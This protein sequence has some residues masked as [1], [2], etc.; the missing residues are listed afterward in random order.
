MA[1]VATLAGP[2]RSAD[3]IIQTLG[4]ALRIA[5]DGIQA[6]DVQLVV[7]M[8]G[9]LTGRGTIAASGAMNFRM[10]ATLKSGGILG[11]VSRLAS[12]GNPDNGVP[13]RVEGTTSNPV[14]T[15]DV[16]AAV[17]NLVKSPNAVAATS[18]ILGKL[19]G[20]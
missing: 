16:T 11:R 7:P 9:S 5:P 10:V 6:N 15:P 18:G 20:K 19:L 4:A 3:T 8:I 1:A 2:A 14:F 17:G 12:L 13:F